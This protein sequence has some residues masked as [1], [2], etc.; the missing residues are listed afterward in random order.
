MQCRY[1]FYILSLACIS[2]AVHKIDIIYIHKEA[3][4]K[5]HSYVHTH[6]RASAVLLSFFLL[7]FFYIINVPNYDPEKQHRT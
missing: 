4:I 7:L 2:L 1:L 3:W 6:A 5:L